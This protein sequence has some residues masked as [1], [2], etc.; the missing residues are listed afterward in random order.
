MS[1]DIVIIN[2]SQGDTIPVDMSEYVFKGDKG[3]D[4]KDG[5]DGINGV[6]GTNGINGTNGYTPIKGIDYFDGATGVA[7]KDG[8]DGITQDISGLIPYTGATTNINLNGK[9]ILN[10]S[11]M[12]IGTLNYTPANAIYWGQSS[13]STYNQFILQNT[14]AGA[15]ASVD[16][17]VSNNLSTDTTYYGDFGMNSSNFVGIGSLSLPN[18]VYL[19]ATSGELVLGTTTNNGMHFVVNGGATDAIS[20]D[21]SGNVTMSGNVSAPNLATKTTLQQVKSMAIAM[22]VV[23]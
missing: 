1:E 22:A 8:K 19:T 10:A 5:V 15:N 16:H 14:N 20:I 12:G 7:G 21:N 11:L 6:N 9:S 4:G 23:L 18:A 3:Q 17:I 13:A 2:I